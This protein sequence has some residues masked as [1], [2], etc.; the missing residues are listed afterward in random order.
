MNAVADVSIEAPLKEML[1]E[2]TRRLVAEF[3][4]CQIYLFG[5]HAWGKP[6]ED[7]DVDLLVVVPDSS[8][9]SSERWMRARHCLSDVRVA[10][11]VLVH[12]QAEVDWDSRVYASLICEILER[13]IKLYG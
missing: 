3:G 2:M 8:E 6:N 9:S 10:K 5:S 12:T 7:S 4:P 11:D 13:G 1:A